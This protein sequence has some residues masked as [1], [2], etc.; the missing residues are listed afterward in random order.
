MLSGTFHRIKHY[1][2]PDVI[3]QTNGYACEQVVSVH[4][5][6]GVARTQP[7]PG[8]FTGWFAAQLVYSTGQPSVNE[9]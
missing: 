2:L 4:E 5:P 7:L 9:Y 1:I 8:P 3:L 6:V